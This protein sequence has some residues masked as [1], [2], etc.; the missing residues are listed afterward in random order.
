[1]MF[2]W[3]DVDRVREAAK[4]HRRLAKHMKPDAAALHRLKAEGYDATADRIEASILDRR[5]TRVHDSASPDSIH[6][7]R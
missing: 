4:R 2:D 3:D 6:E 5:T 7:R 1:M